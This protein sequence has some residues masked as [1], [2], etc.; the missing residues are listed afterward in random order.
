MVVCGVAATSHIGQSFRRIQAEHAHEAAFTFIA[1][2]SDG[3]H[4]TTYGFCTNSFSINPC[5]KHLKCLDGSR[6]S[7]ARPG[8]ASHNFG[9]LRERLVAMKAAAQVNPAR[10]VGTNNQVA[11]AVPLFSG[12][13]T[14]LAAQPEQNVFAGGSDYPNPTAAPIP[15]NLSPKSLTYT[16]YAR[17]GVSHSPPRFACV[18]H[19]AA[20]LSGAHRTHDASLSLEDSGAQGGEV[21]IARETHFP[22][23]IGLRATRTQRRVRL[24]SWK[25]CANVSVASRGPCLTAHLPPGADISCGCDSSVP[26]LHSARSISPL[27]VL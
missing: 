21:V 13:E 24:R 25:R 3:F 18:V 8:R 27:S 26:D 10:S 4:V 17:Y 22:F 11:H 19:T 16:R 9:E 12:V 15:E 1:A 23:P 20:L 7:T 5:A 6:N 14:A 2:S